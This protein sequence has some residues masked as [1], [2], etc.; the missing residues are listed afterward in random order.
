MSKLTI[1]KNNIVK[2]NLGENNMFD[3]MGDALVNK[4]PLQ[5]AI[6][7]TGYDLNLYRIE[8]NTNEYSDAFIDHYSFEGIDVSVTVFLY[9][10]QDGSWGLF[11]S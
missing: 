5:T 8:K 10:Y 6:Q 11:E 1:G 4:N 2:L 3:Y 7:A 9:V